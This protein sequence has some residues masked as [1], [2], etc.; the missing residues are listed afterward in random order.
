MVHELITLFSIQSFLEKEQIAWEI[1]LKLF[2]KFIGV[3]AILASPKHRV[4][5]WNKTP[6]EAFTPPADEKY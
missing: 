5:T 4:F 2:M 6:A 1:V 3:A